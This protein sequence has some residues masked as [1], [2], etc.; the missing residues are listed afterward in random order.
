[1]QPKIQPGAAGHALTPQQAR[2]N[3]LVRDV[4]LWRAALAQWQDN[5][6]RYER[7]TAPLHR[8]LQQAFRQWLFALDSASLQPGLSRAERAQVDE[9]LRETAAA[10]LNAQE[11]DAEVAALLARHPDAPAPP[12]EDALEETDWQAEAEAAA[13][14]REAAAARRRSDRARQRRGK[15]VQEASQSVR[16]VYRRLASVLHPD[17][18][19]DPAL[20]ERKT[21]WM[22]QANQAY[23]DG[24]LLALLELQLQAEQV[25]TRAPA[26]VDERRLQHYIAVLQ[27]QLDEL[28]AET[29]RTE[30]AFRAAAGLP[31]G[32]GMQ[33]RKAERVATAEA[34]RLREELLL[35]ER[36]RR[37]L[38]D[39][40]ATREW[41]RA[42]RR[43]PRLS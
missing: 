38:A 40:D 26:A 11:D 30:A 34:Q 4:A 15:Q 12:A 7:A 2:F 29:R 9:M 3:D 5:V 21:Q 13:A 32:T 14:R 18:E 24:N 16:D 41:L 23:A 8:Q 36:Q 39:L 17:R 20:R 43:A 1:M 19:A 10:L 28:Q 37:L 31:P 33:P 22:Q 6:D 25:H 42:L 27:E 35:L